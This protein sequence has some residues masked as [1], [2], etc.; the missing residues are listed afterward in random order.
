MNTKLE[1]YLDNIDKNLRPLPAS[2]RIDIVKEIKSSI[3]EMENEKLSDEQIL[4]RLGNPKYLAKAY[5][6]DLLASKKGFSISRF[7]TVCAFYSVMG[8]S[9]MIIIPCLA[10]IAPTFI[11]CGIAAPV[12]G[13]VKMTDYIFNLGLPYVQH[14][15]IILSNIELNPVWEFFGLIIIG[16]LL[17]LAGRGAWKLLLCYC[18][19][20]SE[21]K[22]DLLI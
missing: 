13:S 15:V 18:K 22:K 8:F 4:E 1:K 12:L 11:F 5:L 20:V 3:I 7:L 9:G 2:E 17:F 16:A 14:I 10:I 21:T 6:G 19:K